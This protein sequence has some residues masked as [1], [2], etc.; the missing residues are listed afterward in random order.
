MNLE[1]FGQPLLVGV[2]YWISQI[3]SPETRE[4]TIQKSCSTLLSK[5]SR[6]F[7]S[8]RTSVIRHWSYFAARDSQTQRQNITIGAA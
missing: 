1:L 7:D 4:R 6:L 3:P 8:V 5:Q 2:E